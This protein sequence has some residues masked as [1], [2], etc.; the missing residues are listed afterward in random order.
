MWHVLAT[1]AEF[2]LPLVGRV[3]ELGRV[4]IAQLGRG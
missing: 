3:A 4:A 2:T 1:T